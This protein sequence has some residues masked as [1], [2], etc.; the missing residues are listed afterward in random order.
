VDPVANSSRSKIAID[1][2]PKSEETVSKI[3][4]A[5]FLRLEIALR[6]IFLLGST[7]R[8]AITSAQSSTSISNRING[9]ESK[10]M[11]VLGRGQCLIAYD[12]SDKD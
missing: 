6:A 9:K 12:G 10:G 4:F 2:F 3:L 8:V 1:F 7:W 5:Y 11:Q